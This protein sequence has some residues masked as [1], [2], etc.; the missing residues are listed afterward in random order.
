MTDVMI[1]NH[2]PYCFCHLP[3]LYCL[4]L[5]PQNKTVMLTWRIEIL[6]QLIDQMPVTTKSL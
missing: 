6:S 3:F 1:T 4:S 5:I 2:L